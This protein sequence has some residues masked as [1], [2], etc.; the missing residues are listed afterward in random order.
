VKGDR[1]MP[2]L[3]LIPA[4][5]CP[6]EKPLR[7]PTEAARTMNEARSEAARGSRPDASAPSRGSSEDVLRAM[8]E[9]SRRADTL[10]R[11]LDVI[12]HLGGDDDDG[13]D[14]DDRPRAA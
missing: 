6:G 5:E 13:D 9:V 14:D 12:G 1:D 10:L 8:R 4:D 3:R 2:T 7:F 11:D